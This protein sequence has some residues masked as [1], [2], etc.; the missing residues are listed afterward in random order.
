[1]A[2]DFR[3]PALRRS[4]TGGSR[5]SL[6][7][8]AS[9]TIL[10]TSRDVNMELFAK[11]RYPVVRAWRCRLFI[12]DQPTCPAMLTRPTLGDLFH[13]PTHRSLGNRLPGTRPFPKWRWRDAVLIQSS[14]ALNGSSLRPGGSAGPV[15]R[16][17]PRRT[18]GRDR[19]RQAQRRVCLEEGVTPRSAVRLARWCRRSERWT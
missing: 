6:P 19:G 7:N 9:E 4:R 8:E 3:E 1:M 13:P 11:D 14:G 16:A 5:Y 18:A 12:A 15:R 10:P 17:P 2:G